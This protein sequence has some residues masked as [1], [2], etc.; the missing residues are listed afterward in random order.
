VCKNR[1]VPSEVRTFV[2]ASFAVAAFA[3]GVC[4]CV[5]D[6]TSG[7]TP[8]PPA[9]ACSPDATVPD[10]GPPLD[11]PIPD[12]QPDS[13]VPLEGGTTFAIHQ[14]LLG[15]T[16]RDGT[17]DMNAWAQYGMNLD[18]KVT[19]A[20]STDVCTAAQGAPRVTQV[21]GANGI[22]NSWGENILPIVMFGAGNGTAS[23]NN[24]AIDKGVWTLMLDVANLTTD[25]AQTAPS[26]PAQAFV[27]ALFPG[28]PTWT[29][30]DSWPVDPSLLNDGKT[31]AR[32]STTQFPLASIAM[33]AWAGGATGA[34][35]VDINFPTGRL[36][37]T[38]HLP[39]VTFL[40]TQPGQ[41]TMGVIA[42]ILDPPELLAAFVAAVGPATG[43]SICPRS[44]TFNSLT[45][46]LMQAQDI[47][48]DGT[49]TPGVPCN[50]VSIGLGF[51]A[52]EIGPPQSVGMPPPPVADPCVPDAG[53]D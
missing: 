53:A 30:A 14:M 20:C 21:D 13:P 29:P 12:A 4:G 52:D 44:G 22:D 47:L 38:V 2:Q 33:G 18:G 41:A 31:I 19:S 48:L 51:T 10:A 50:A 28:T 27:G 5:K 8:T 37:L 43:G 17:A 35:P 16:S 26:T 25:P 23:T 15:D 6:A 32:G 7:P 34:I 1:V 40:H 46:L 42:G 11:I 24:T 45:K 36:H 9:E 49:N 39:R 3:L